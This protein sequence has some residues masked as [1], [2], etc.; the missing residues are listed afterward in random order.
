[1]KLLLKF[2]L[3]FIL[4]FACALGAAGYVSWT[5]LEKNAREEIAQNARLL[6]DT[7]LATRTYTSSQVNP[8][9]ETQMKYTFLPQSVPA[10]SAT[11]VLHQ[12]F[13]ISP[14][15]VIPPGSYRWTRFRTEVNTATKRPWVVDF[16]YRWG[17]FYDGTL[18]QY[19][20]GL[21]MKPSTHVAVALQM[22]R[23]EGTLPTGRS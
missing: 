20:P 10:Y 21:T 4:I 18:R 9:L 3:V 5:L 14:G 1:M 7:A 12:P 22:E 8:L 13:Q 17:S 15:V 19:Q 6:M 16:A 23:D 2:N 11:E